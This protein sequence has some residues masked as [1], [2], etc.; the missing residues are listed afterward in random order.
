[1]QSRLL[2]TLKLDLGIKVADVDEADEVDDEDDIPVHVDSSFVVDDDDCG[3]YW[4][5]NVLLSIKVSIGI[6]ILK[7]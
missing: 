5:Y 6:W 4:V 1:M 3:L 7:K 2:F